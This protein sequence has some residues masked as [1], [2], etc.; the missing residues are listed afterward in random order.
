[1]KKPE[2]PV[3]REITVATDVTVSPQVV[4][5][6]TPHYVGHRERLRTRYLKNGINALSEYEVLELLLTYAS[7]RK[8][9]KP[10]AK[11]L[12]KRF[13]GL[14]G[15][16]DAPVESLTEVKGVGRRT[17]LLMKL[18]KDMGMLYLKEQQ[19]TKQQLGSPRQIVDYLRVAFGSLKDEHFIVLFL[20]ANSEIVAE[21]LISVGTVNETVVQPRKIF[22]KALKHKATSMILVHNHPGG[23]LKP[24]PEDINLTK[25]LLDL[26]YGLGIRILDHL[27]VTSNGY[28]SFLEKG[29]L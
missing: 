29:L 21:E 17:A 16:L 9:V 4:V 20:N 19:V 6:E 5:A 24:T 13:K 28:V 22:E 10:E 2:V 25:R 11:E 18:V 27:I 26:S 15:V 23:T 3:A 12:F 7:P 1:M 14:K 8:D